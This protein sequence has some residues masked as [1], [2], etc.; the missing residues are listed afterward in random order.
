MGYWEHD[1]SYNYADNASPTLLAAGF[2]EQVVSG[3][4]TITVTLWPIV[5]DT[6]FTAAGQ[7]TA[8]PTVTN[9][10]PGTVELLP[11][12]WNVTWLVSTRTKSEAPYTLLDTPPNGFARLIQAQQVV[13]GS[14]S[15]DL[16]LKSKSAIVRGA[17]LEDFTATDELTLSGNTLTLDIEGYTKGFGRIKKEG[18]VNFRLEYVPFHLTVQDEENPWTGFD[19]DSY[20]NLAGENL[21]VWIIRNGINDSAQNADTDFAKFNKEADY[22]GNGAVSFKGAV[23]QN[24]ALEITAGEFKG[25]SN[26]NT[27]EIKFTTGSGYTGNA[28]VWYAVVTANAPAPDYPDYYAYSSTKLGSVGPGTTPQLQIK[29]PGSGVGTDGYDVYVVLFKDGELSAPLKI[30][31]KEGDIKIEI[32][33]GS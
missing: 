15:T 8:E 31:T 11:V 24:A 6:K 19:N 13:H 4:G 20:F 12:G 26:S 7:S 10:Q 25:P 21:P 29:L 22:N 9:G 32:P 14:E 33:W 17:G 28:E 30:K 1:G 23:S 16:L 2:R 18:S 27:P 5:A 3:S